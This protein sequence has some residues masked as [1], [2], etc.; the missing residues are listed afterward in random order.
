M[1]LKFRNTRRSPL[2]YYCEKVVQNY[3]TN[4]KENIHTN[5]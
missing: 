3:V 1:N 5:V 2:R 4:L